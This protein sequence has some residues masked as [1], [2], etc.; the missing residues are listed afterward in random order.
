MIW[1]SVFCWGTDDCDDLVCSTECNYNFIYTNRVTVYFHSLSVSLNKPSPTTVSS[2][3]Y[4]EITFN[5]DLLNLLTIFCS[6]DF[7]YHHFFSGSI[8]WAASSSSSLSSAVYMQVAAINWWKQMK[9]AS[10]KASRFSS[11][12]P[13]LSCFN[14]CIC[15]VELTFHHSSVWSLNNFLHKWRIDELNLT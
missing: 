9:A 3:L 13:P 12:S 7:T 15:N 2:S 1:K 4:W 11:T 10:V 6:R 5:N 14:P 8:S